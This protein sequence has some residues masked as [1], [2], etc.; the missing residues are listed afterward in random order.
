MF[1]SVRKLLLMYLHRIK[2]NL[3][4]APSILPGFRISPYRGSP[5]NL[6]GADPSSAH[7]IENPCKRKSQ[8][9]SERAGDIKSINVIVKQSSA[10]ANASTHMFFCPFLFVFCLLLS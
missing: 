9:F 2:P 8:I 3:F 7:V 1:S 6:E 10:G 4:S 5:N